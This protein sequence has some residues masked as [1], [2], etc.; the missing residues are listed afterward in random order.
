MRGDDGSRAVDRLRLGK[1]ERARSARE[2]ESRR[3]MRAFERGDLATV[4]SAE[5]RATEMVRAFSASGFTA[6]SMAVMAFVGVDR[7]SV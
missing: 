5:F 7:P 4:R 2:V 1:W 6:A 3:L